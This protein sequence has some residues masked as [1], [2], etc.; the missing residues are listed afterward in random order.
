MGLVCVVVVVVWKGRAEFSK[1]RLSLIRSWAFYVAGLI[2][3]LSGGFGW[4]LVSFLGKR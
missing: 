2:F 3:I 1:A 4:L